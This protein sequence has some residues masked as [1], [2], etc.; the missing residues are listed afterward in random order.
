MTRAANVLRLVA[1]NV[2]V[3]AVLAEL[4]AAAFYFV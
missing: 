1:V 3:L 4:G 2:V